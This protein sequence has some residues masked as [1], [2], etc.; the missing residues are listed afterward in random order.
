MTE[1]VRLYILIKTVSGCRVLM[2]S[3]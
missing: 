3:N 1:Y 2:S